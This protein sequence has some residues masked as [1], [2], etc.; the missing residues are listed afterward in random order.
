[1]TSPI[2]PQKVFIQ[3][4]NSGLVLEYKPDAT[5]EVVIAQQSTL[6]SQRWILA[7]SGVTGYMYIQSV[8]DNNVITAGDAKQ[9]PLIVAPKRDGLDL[10]QLWIQ[11]EPGS[12]TNAHFVLMSAKTGNVMDVKGADK[13]P[14]TQ[15]QIFSHSNSSNQQFAIKFYQ[16]I[17]G[18]S[19]GV[20][21]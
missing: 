18:R 10:N 2:S 9:D 13:T 3:D 20:I 21:S 1:M 6:S 12:G 19:E 11:H 7:D 5:Y 15:V 17:H 8:V 16:W 4:R 14:G